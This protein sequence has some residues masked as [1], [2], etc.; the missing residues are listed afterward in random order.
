[1]NVARQVSMIGIASIGMMFVI[2]TGGIDLSVGAIVQFVNVV[3]AYLMVTAGWHPI[4]AIFACIVLSVLAGMTNGLFITK[5]RIPP[6]IS[7]MAMMTALGGLAFIISGGMPIFGFSEGFLVLGQGSVGNVPIPVVLMVA[8][9]IFGHFFLKK[10]YF[11]RYFFAIGGNEEASNLSGINVVRT[12]IIVYMLS[13][14]FASI[15]G[16]IMLSRL[17]S[18]VATTGR[19]FE[20]EV[21]TAVILGGV[22]IS[23]G[24]GRV[25]G[26]IMGVLIMGVLFNGLILMGMGHHV[27]QVIQGIVLFAA[28]SIDCI[29]KARSGK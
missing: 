16:V 6:F 8:V 11:G 23:G 21:I 5:A 18:G 24:S 7:T 15:A 19:G 29:T 10:T 13:S 25:F 12:K 22:S 4:L 9:L 3:A 27:Q 28:V 17:G 2:L 1:M 20:F 26:V 14:F